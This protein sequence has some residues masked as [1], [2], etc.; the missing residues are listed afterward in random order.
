MWLARL[1]GALAKL[2]TDVAHLASTEVGEVAEPHSPGRGGSSAMPHKR[3]PVSATVILAAHA[4]SA[5]HIG[6]LSAAMAAA[7]ER[8][9]GAWHAEWLALP[10]LFGL[11]SGALREAAAL[12]EGMVIDAARMERN[13]GLTRGLIFADVA[14]AHLAAGLGRAAAHAA[15]QRGAGLVR[16]GSA[17]TLREALQGDPS[18]PL[19]A[20][21]GMEA[22]FDI[23]PSVSAAAIWTDRALQEVRAIQVRWRQGH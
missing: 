2:A 21:G 8:P 15:V 3:N 9:P 1:A 13:L 17:A 4:A 6:T 5:G 16:D 14:A 20:R 18:I 11:L 19:E 23:G 10:Q 7:H 22:A 12:A